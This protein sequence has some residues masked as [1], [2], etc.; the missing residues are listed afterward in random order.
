MNKHNRPLIPQTKNTA[1]AKTP[2]NPQPLQSPQISIETQRRFQ[3]PIPAPDDLKGYGELDPGF[4]DR[5]LK[6]AEN[7]A[8]ADVRRKNTESN[9]IILGQIFSFLLSMIS[10]GSCI[11]LGTKGLTAEAITAAVGGF[12]PIIIA[13]LSNFKKK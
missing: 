3:G 5:I 1:P 4:P 7:H 10:I 8:V 13:A 2:V 9:S 12:T 11:Y 6:M